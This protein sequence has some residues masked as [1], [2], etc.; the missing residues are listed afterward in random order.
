MGAGEDS[1]SNPSFCSEEV[2]PGRAGECRESAGHKGVGR[3]PIQAPDSA[4]GC[5]R[6][7]LPVGMLPW[8]SPAV[9]PNPKRLHSRGGLGLVRSSSVTQ[10]F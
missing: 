2:K 9:P 7:L 1:D 8:R 4:Q 6:A 5:C 3:V 10:A